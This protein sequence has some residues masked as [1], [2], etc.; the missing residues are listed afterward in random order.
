[1]KFYLVVLGLA[2]ITPPS[3][4]AASATDAQQAEAQR[5]SEQIQ[6]QQRDRLEQEKREE[7]LKRPHSNI[8]IDPPKAPSKTDDKICHD[9]KQIIIEG[10]A[11]LSDGDRAELAAPFIG[12][13]VKSSD[14][15]RLLSNIT[16]TYMDKGFISTR[17]YI[18]P[19]DL[20]K[21]ILRILVVEGTVEKI[22]I[23]DGDENSSIN[24]FTAFPGVEGDSLNLRDI[25]QGLDQ[26]NRI[27]SNH[28]TMEVKPGTKA[29]DSVIVI[30]NQKTR[31]L[32]GNF[33]FDNTGSSNTGEN[34]VSF[35]A[36]ADNTLGINDSFS[37]T[38]RRTIGD[39]FKNI[40]SRMY[41]FN[42]SVPLGYLTLNASHT[43]T[44]YV[45]TIH[46]PGGDLLSSGNTDNTSV[47]AEYVVY[48]DAINLLSLA[49][50]LTVKSTDNYLAGNFL[51][52]ASRTLSTFDLGGRWNTQ[53]LDGAM[54]LNIDYVI[55]LD[56]F[57]ALED[58]LGLAKFAPHAQFRKWTLGL[59][60]M[61]P[62]QLFEQNFLFN[63]ALSAQYGVDALYGTEQFM[64]GN[65][66]NVRG[67]RNTSISGDTGYYWRNDLSMPFQLQIESVPVNIKPYIAYDMGS[68][69]SRYSSSISGAQ[70]GGDLIGM[71]FG[72]NASIDRFNFDVSGAKPLSMPNQLKD[73]GL[74]LFAR[75][76]VQL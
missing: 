42:Y 44:D 75:F 52:I 15:E 55:G 50:T 33:S 45:T 70:L 53:V 63:T 51:E 16:Q 62:F 54:S 20:S 41:T 43:M 9:V 49:G 27:S 22:I 21:G 10:A 74:Q 11:L 2:A 38:H 39:K 3:V 14:I 36:I 24:L 59:N 25:E 7:L 65:P 48:R 35:S 19:Q 23:D 30:H 73:E 31:R 69:C 17:A 37:F 76:S 29:G 13:C 71:A 8:K 32:H 1:M 47:G 64:V 72:I 66:S 12:Q 18:Q 60:W 67:Y 68:I 61:R 58:P 40:H 34:Q 5:A 6:R 57:N 4:F 46:P 26:I 28:A 56:I